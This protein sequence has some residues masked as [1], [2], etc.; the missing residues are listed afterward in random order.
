MA[1]EVAR[2]PGLP[3]D[4]SLNGAAVV[5]PVQQNPDWRQHAVLE[6]A[7]R[8]TRP[9]RITPSPQVAPALKLSII[10]ATFNEEQT[11][12]RAIDEVLSVEFPCQIELIIVDD[13]STDQ[14]AEILSQVSDPR[15]AV[16]TQPA[17][18]GKGRALLTGLAL[19]TGTHVVP[20]DA[21]LEY[22]AQ[23]ITRMLE[24]VL[25]GR[26]SVVYGARLFGYNT[27]YRSYWY[28]MGNRVLTRLTNVLYGACISDLHTCL[29]LMPVSLMR[30]LSLREDGFGLDTELTGALLRRGVRPFEVPVSYFSRLHSEG[31]KISW[32][33]AVECLRILLR[34]RVHRA[35]RRVAAARP[36]TDDHVAANLQ[37]SKAAASEAPDDYAV[38]V[39]G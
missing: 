9:P 36:A 38:R 27:V 39:T 14:T 4:K 17:N 21:D 23:D 26:C 37:T 16:T 6:D 1:A 25:R 29:K 31:K 7:A 32:R 15:V 22:V 18:Y 35:Y 30:D 33:D 2:D 8:L 3:A 20:F 10:M 11:I 24:P 34:V 13:G 5:F 19:A 12:S 28:A